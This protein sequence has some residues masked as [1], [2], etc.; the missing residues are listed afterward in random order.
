MKIKLL[1]ILTC[2]IVLPGLFAQST[3]AVFQESEEGTRASLKIQF[4][5]SIPSDGTI[6]IASDDRYLYI[7]WHNANK[8]LKMTFDGVPVG[9]YFSV[10]GMEGGLTS[11]TYDGQYFW[12]ISHI[13]PFLYKIDMDAE[14]PVLVNTFSLPMRSAFHCE[15]DPTAD[16]GNGG[17]WIGPASSPDLTLVSKTGETLTTIS[18]NTHGL[19]SIVGTAW[20]NTIP[21]GPY[22]WTLNYASNEP[23]LL[24]QLKLPQGI[25]AKNNHNLTETIAAPAGNGG[26]M[27]VVKDIVKETTTLVVLLQ[28]S[29]V[30]GL[31]LEKLQIAPLDIG[32]YSLDLPGAFP[33]EEDYV[34]SG[35]IKNY[36]TTTVKSFTLNYQVNNGEVKSQHFS[37][38]TI[39]PSAEITFQHQD[40]A[41]PRLGSNTIKVWTSLPNGAEDQ[42]TNNDTIEFT[43]VIYDKDNVVPRTVLLEGF[44]S[45][46]CP[47]CVY[48]NVKLKE[49][50]SQN[51]GLYALIKYQTNIPSPGDPYYTAEVGERFSHYGVSGV[52]HIVLDG[53]IGEST[54]DLTNELLEQLQSLPAFVKLNVD[55]SVQDDIVSATARINS[56]INLSNPDIKLFITVIEKVT[57]QNIGTN[58]EKEFNQVMKKF[59][60]EAGGIGVG[61][62]IA[63]TDAIF[64]QKW[65]FKGN[66]RKP[67]GGSDPINHD[68]EHSIEDF[69]NL[70][71]IAW[72]QNVKTK[73]I[74]QAASA[75]APPAT[76][77]TV[78]FHTIEE[79]GGTL[80]A[81]I[82]GNSVESGTP[83]EIGAEMIFVAAPATGY[84]IKEWKINNEAVSDNTSPE[85]RITVE[86]KKTTITVEFEDP[87]SINAPLFQDIKLYPNPVQ[88]ELTISGI[89]QVNKIILSDISGKSI[90]EIGN[91]ASLLTIDMGGLAKGVYII[92]L[93][94]ADGEKGVYKIVK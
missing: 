2:F 53:T 56:T 15:Y 18:K 21:G 4:E 44:T 70:Q 68:I 14:P 71:V 7:T 65:E 75:D 94:T 38:V 58:G 93:Y 87:T 74:Y 17:L 63:N 67:A 13:T 39:A 54:S 88:N 24:K 66:Y 6:G 16:E 1:S 19:S 31:E 81:S 30:V 83:V 47:P 89:E 40:K 33:M 79:Y 26:D 61:N 25:Q 29:K 23:V 77:R 52:P 28:N 78:N 59:M 72:I 41:A 80:T 84:R 73:E 91:N 35:K 46:T 32:V 42:D 49:V 12:G 20:E 92:T 90:K 82:N 5:F 60:P 45:S 10:S 57:T 43:S 9:D 50:L 22:L 62:I 27:C 69:D 36:G 55:V 48:G 86:N 51:N 34:I 3:T 85:L 64:Q 8:W 11:L 37:G 76:L